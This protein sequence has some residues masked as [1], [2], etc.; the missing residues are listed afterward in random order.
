MAKSENQKLKLLYLMKI[1]MEETDSYHGLTMPDIIDLL[2]EYDVKAERKSLYDD[3]EMLNNFGLD[4]QGEK[5]GKSYVY[6]MAS[7]DFELPELKLLVDAVQS[8]KFITQNKSNSLIKKLESLASVYEGKELHRQVYVANRTK[9]I[10]ESI[11]YNVDYIQQA[12]ADNKQI[13]FKYFQWNYKKEQELRH[14]GKNYVISPWAL[15]W[16][17][18]NYYMVGYDAEED[19]IKHFRV[20]KM[21][22]ITVLEDKRL[23][24]NLFKQFDM[25]VYSNKVFGMYGGKEETVALLCD[26]DMAGVIIDRFGKDVAIREEDEEHFVT[27]VNVAVSPQFFGW[28][29]SLGGKVKIISPDSVVDAMKK[30]IK[31]QMNLYK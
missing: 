5:V 23:G 14:D 11:F 13:T 21:L 18:E 3:I 26:K 29:C 25:A 15:T 4:I 31:K 20:D 30:E 8:S 6:Y 24:K 1:F 22:K 2:E 17:D 28:V 9:T 16:D 7:R 19:K 27:R 10:N 12:I